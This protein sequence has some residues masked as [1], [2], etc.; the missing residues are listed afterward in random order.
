VLLAEDKDL[1]YVARKIKEEYEKYGM[2]INVEKTKYLCVG[3]DGDNL[4]RTTIK[5]YNAVKK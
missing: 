4:I 3:T 5:Q 1:E 2:T